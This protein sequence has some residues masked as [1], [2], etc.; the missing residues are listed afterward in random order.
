MGS[1]HM[2][3][4]GTSSFNYHLDHGFVVF[5]DVQLRFS[6]RR[7]CV[8]GNII[9]F[10]QVL[11]LLSS[12]DMLG[13]GFG[14]GPR[15]SPSM[16]LWLGLL[17][18]ILQSQSLKDREQVA[19]PYVVQHP[20]KWYQTLWSCAR[21]KFVYCTS[22]CLEQIFCFQNTQDISWGWLWVLKISNKVWVLKQT[23]SAI[24]C[25]VSHMTM[26]TIVSCVMNV[27]NQPC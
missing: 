12:F 18:V 6:L 3:H 16:T 14:I 15:T 23:H 22:N 27:W 19:H 11:N 4:R 26:L 25:R 24:L 10:T 20:E 21:Q 2:S 8:N 9:H 5:E 13:L 17:N 7:M 1:W